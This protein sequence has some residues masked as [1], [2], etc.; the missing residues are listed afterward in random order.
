MQ[1]EVFEAAMSGD[2]DMFFATALAWLQRDIDFDGL[3]WGTRTAGR[4]DAVLRVHGRPAAMAHEHGR[5]AASDPVTLRAMAAPDEVHALA[6]GIVC[7]ADAQALA[8][9]HGYDTRQ[10]MILAKPDHADEALGII[11]VL[12]ASDEPFPADQRRAMRRTA[13]AIL[14]AQQLREAKA[15]RM[16]A[17]PQPAPG[18]ALTEREMAVAQAYAD[19]RSVKEVARLMG[20]SV[21][22]VQCH[23]ARVY[24][25]LDVHSKIAL[26]KILGDRRARPRVA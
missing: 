19:G 26:R 4:T 9:W 10:L 8:F 23:L 1:L 24:R 2:D 21:S 18:A 3:L 6:T 25:K 15:T 11:G 20:V 12:R 17:P 13:Q 14:L 22:T 5:I 7:A 16:A